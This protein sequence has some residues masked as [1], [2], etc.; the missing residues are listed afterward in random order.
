ML[1]RALVALLAE[2]SRVGINA[3]LNCLNSLAD[4]W[5]VDVS[6]LSLLLIALEIILSGFGI[7][8]WRNSKLRKGYTGRE[9]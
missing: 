2:A 5:P 9:N 8:R 4:R 3:R 6:G 7:R 1:V